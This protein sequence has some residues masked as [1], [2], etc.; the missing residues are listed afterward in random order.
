MDFDLSP[1]HAL[2]RSTVRDFMETEVEP[3]VEEHE[4]DHRF[5]TDIVRRL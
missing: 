1:E 2:L 4:K 3:I 5:P